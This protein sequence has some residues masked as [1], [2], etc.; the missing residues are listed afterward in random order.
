MTEPQDI[1]L[2]LVE[3]DDIDA[4][5]IRRAFINNKIVNPI[6][7]AHDGIE[8]LTLLDTEDFNGPYIILLDLNMPRMGGVEFLKRLRQHPVHSNAVV[9]VLTTSNADIDIAAS[10]NE[11]ISGY[12]VKSEMGSNF[13]DIAK[14]FDGYW[15]MVKLP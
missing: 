8:A 9:F 6:V 1:I 13:F 10:Y 7:R 3:D 2:L 15:K 12:F 11:K 5:G 4:E 14:L